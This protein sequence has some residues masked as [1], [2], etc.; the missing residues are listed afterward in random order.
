MRITSS[1]VMNGQRKKVM[2]PLKIK[3][4]YDAA[5][6]KSAVLCSLLLDSPLTKDTKPLTLT[7]TWP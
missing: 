5:R 7:L 4:N 2:K 3:G 1:V 6:A